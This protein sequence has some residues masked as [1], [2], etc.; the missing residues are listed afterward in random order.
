[1]NSNAG[2]ISRHEEGVFGLINRDV[3]YSFIY[4]LILD[5]V[6]KYIT[7]IGFEFETDAMYPCIIQKDESGNM[8]LHTL[9]PYNK[10]QRFLL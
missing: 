7:S 1:M 10:N 2:V 3:L 4:F 5:L 6:F 9:E 8:E